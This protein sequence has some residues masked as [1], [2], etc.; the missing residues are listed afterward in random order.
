MLNKYKYGILF[1]ENILRGGKKKSDLSKKDVTELEKHYINEN[2]YGDGETFKVEI[3][4]TVNFNNGTIIEIYPRSETVGC[5]VDNKG[6]IK[7]II[8][9]YENF[10][11]IIDNL[12]ADELRGDNKLFESEEIYITHNGTS[13]KISDI[14]KKYILDELT[15]LHFSGI[16]YKKYKMDDDLTD[17]ILSINN[18]SIIID[19]SED[20]VYSICEN[21][22]IKEIQMPENL[23]N[24]IKKLVN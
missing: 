15:K 10:I 13:Q 16:G 14:E 4:Y 20:A 11:N 6:N 9:I 1:V 12:Y 22:R 18:N 2:N 8:Q 3:K 24:Y 21:E 17:Y 7:E 5:I 19:Y 23:K